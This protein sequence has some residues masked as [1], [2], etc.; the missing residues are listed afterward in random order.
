MKFSNYSLLSLFYGLII[1][2]FT[3][4][5]FAQSTDEVVLNQHPK[6]LVSSDRFNKSRFTIVTGSLAVSYSAALVGLNE[7]WYKDFPRS[8]FHFINDIKEWQQ[9]D[10]AGHVVTPYLEA[11]YIMQTFQWAGL[12]SRKAAIWGG[13]TA[14][15]FQNTIEV[16]D[17]F[18]AEWGASGSDLAANFLGA[19]IMTGQE[20]LWNEQRMSL[21]VMPHFFR[22][23]DPELQQ[24]ADEL[25]GTNYIVRF[26]KDYNAINVWASINTAS[27]FPSQRR[28]KW[29]NIAVGYG[30]GGMFG[31][32]SNEWIDEQGIYHDRRDVVR[33][34]K[35]YLSL[36]VDFHR[37]P[38][39]SR[40]LRLLF[41][42]LNIIKVPAPAIEFNTKGQVLFHPLI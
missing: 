5:M 21:K 15:M 17:G 22:Y 16:F 41:D 40:Y 18:S 25:Y 30:A 12:D 42:A 38:T 6:W 36:D 35:L 24:R 37:I 7:L 27:F 23:D 10:K 39:R 9:I 14:F 3:G 29:L 13:F 4:S 11:R 28:L 26:V 8:S 31:G 2:S 20:L 19:A 33:Y 34:R 32:Y 1:A